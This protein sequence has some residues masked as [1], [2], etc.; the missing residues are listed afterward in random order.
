MQEDVEGS[1][2]PADKGRMLFVLPKTAPDGGPSLPL[3]SRTAAT[4][5]RRDVRARA[6]ATDAFALPECA[7]HLPVG[8]AVSPP[9]RGH[10]RQPF[11]AHEQGLPLARSVVLLPDPGRKEIFGLVLRSKAVRQLRA[12]DHPRRH[13]V[14][15]AQPMTGS[16]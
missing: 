3:V 2:D 14:G 9:S 7:A 12:V 10:D 16:S 11:P 6:V 4:V 5:K 13:Y 1:A 8:L 15:A